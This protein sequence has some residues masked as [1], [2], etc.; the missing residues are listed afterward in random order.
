[1]MRLS[2]WIPAPIPMRGRLFAG[3]TNKGATGLPR[4]RLVLNEVKGLAMTGEI[5][6]RC[7]T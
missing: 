2:K 5:V 3:M 6:M 7:S 1:M 4:L